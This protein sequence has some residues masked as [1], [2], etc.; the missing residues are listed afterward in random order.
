MPSISQQDYIII[1][2]DTF[3]SVAPQDLSLEVRKA[4][5]NAIENGTIM[6]VLL[7]FKDTDNT[8]ST[9]RVIGYA[10]QSYE[11]APYYISYWCWEDDRA[12]CGGFNTNEEEIPQ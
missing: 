3:S 11:D 7:R 12:V 10:K 4:I 9:S 5:A 8:L 1:D 6:D 2:V